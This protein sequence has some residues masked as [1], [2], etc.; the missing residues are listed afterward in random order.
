METY[1]YC[2]EYCTNQFVPKRRGVQRFCRASCRASFFNRNKK[3]NSASKVEKINES[4]TQKPVQIEKMSLPGIGNAALGTFAANVVTNFFTSED[5]KSATKNDI[6][7]LIRILKGRYFR[8]INIPDRKD[9]AKAYY[10]I[11]TQTYIY[12]FFN[13]S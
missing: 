8:I 3:N 1:Y 11:Q 4:E 9:G 13:L 6:K 2:C 12:S 7:N 5:N 10:D